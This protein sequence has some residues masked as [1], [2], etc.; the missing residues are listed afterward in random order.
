[1]KKVLLDQLI[2]EGDVSY[3]NNKP[4]TG[5]AVNY[6]ANKR[7]YYKINFVDGLKE[8]ELLIFRENAKLH[9]TYTYKND[10]KNGEY[11][12]YDY[13][14]SLVL[15]QGFYLNDLKTGEWVKYFENGKIDTKRSYIEDKENGDCEIYYKTGQLKAKGSFENGVKS[16]LWEYFYET[17]NLKGKE[18]HLE[19]V[20]LLYNEDGSIISRIDLK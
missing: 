4:Y 15:E 20:Q 13:K 5:I 12:R 3:Y 18:D 6:H 10:E 11:I 19:G 1:M 17:G 9:S 8:G 2:D 14:G 7:I 16:G